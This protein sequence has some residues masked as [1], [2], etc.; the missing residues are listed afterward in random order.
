MRGVGDRIGKEDI[1]IKRLPCRRRQQRNLPVTGYLPML[2]PLSSYSPEKRRP[3]LSHVSLSIIPRGIFEIGEEN[4]VYRIRGVSID[5][6][7][8]VFYSSTKIYRRSLPS[9]SKDARFQAWSFRCFLKT[10]SKTKPIE[11]LDSVHRGRCASIELS[12]FPTNEYS[13]RRIR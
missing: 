13:S 10:L 3:T 8:I 11:Y 6:V 7:F 5:R 9:I 4:R 1:S 2:L 12:I